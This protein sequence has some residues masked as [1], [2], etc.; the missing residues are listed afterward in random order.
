MGDT[1]TDYTDMSLLT[2][3]LWLSD[4]GGEYRDIQT[5]ISFYKKNRP[6]K[7]E[8]TNTGLVPL[9]YINST[10]KCLE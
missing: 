7:R 10:E 5:E 8:E 4:I 2:P 9:V 6:K 1:Y 3:L